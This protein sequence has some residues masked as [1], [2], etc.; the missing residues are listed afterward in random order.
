[1]PDFV[2]DSDEN[3]QIMIPLDGDDRVSTLPKRKK[4]ISK[5]LRDHYGKHGP[6][7]QSERTCS[8]TTLL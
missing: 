6:P 7:W 4:V 5:F 3:G 1:M 8:N 2:L